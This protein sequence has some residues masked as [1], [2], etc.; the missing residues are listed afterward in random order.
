[1]HALQQG[2]PG[3]VG[4]YRLLGRLGAGGM[5]VVYLAATPGR[6][7]VALKRVHTALASDPEFR[8][9]FAR[10]V[11]A[12]RA[13][14]GLCTARVIDADTDDPVPYLVTEYVD[15]P[16]LQEEV[17]Q[18][19]PLVGNRSVALA[20][21]LA[22]ALTAIHAAAVSHRDLKPAN[23]L[24][25][26][27]GPKVVDFGIAAALG[28]ASVTRPGIVMGTPSWL[29]PEHVDGEGLGPP[30]DV[31]CWGSLVVYAVTGRPPF[32]GET[33]QASLARV[34]HTAPDLSALPPEL[35]TPVA[36]ALRKD[37]ARRPTAAQLLDSLAGS[38]GT[39]RQAVTRVL[40]TWTPEEP[41]RRLDTETQDTHAADTSPVRPARRRRGSMVV[42]GAAGVAL[43][44]GAAALAATGLVGSGRGHRSTSAHT[45][46]STSPTPSPLVR[47]AGVTAAGYV[48]YT[49]P[50]YGMRDEVPQAL[51]S[52][53]TPARSPSGAVG[54][55]FS[56]PDGAVSMTLLAWPNASGLTPAQDLSS[57]LSLEQSQGS[58]V[59]YSSR[60]GAVAAVSGFTP[61][62]SRIFYRRDVV[63]GTV[64]YSLSWLFPANQPA[65]KAQ[66][67][68]TA[69]TFHPNPAP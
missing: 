9:R 58:T 3:Q 4:R 20:A 40:S 60:S 31:F 29:S 55:T 35:A 18:N 62:G 53:S 34:L 1:M 47:E 15:G 32:A 56:T 30:A 44:A 14:A 7:L 5:G 42:A 65:Y 37:P 26:A 10:E 2:D 25:A 64:V 12:T 59:T 13:V 33:P 38:N 45:A 54:E 69:Q 27:S 66:V 57:L 43:V 8:L 41:T 48:T 36:A 28:A 17:A 39:P 22:E 21:G 19:G 50:R 63:T 67:D 16:S 46:A 6:N 11:T 24:L 51:S 23:V 52:T 61:G 68:H 49:A